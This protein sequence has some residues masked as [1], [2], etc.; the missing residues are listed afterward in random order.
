MAFIDE[1]TEETVPTKWLKDDNHC[2]FPPK[3][4]N[5]THMIKTLAPVDETFELHRCTV[6]FAAGESS[7]I[8]IHCPPGFFRKHDLR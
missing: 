4:A 6:L 1:N 5:K 2:W 8:Y 7:D 3:G